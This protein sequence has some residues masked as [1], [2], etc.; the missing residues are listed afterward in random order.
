MRRPREFL[1]DSTCGKPNALDQ[2]H[3][4]ITGLMVEGHLHRHSQCEVTFLMGKATIEN[5]SIPKIPVHKS[6]EDLTPIA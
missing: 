1:K 5:I 6:K 3:R 4:R 2:I